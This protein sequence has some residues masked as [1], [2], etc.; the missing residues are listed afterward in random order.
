MKK[1]ILIGL[2]LLTSLLIQ[3]Q[4]DNTQPEYP[5]GI[6][7]GDTLQVVSED[8]TLW[9]ITDHQIRKTIKVNK[10]YQLAKEEV[11]LLQQKI[12]K[13]EKLNAQ[14]DTLAIKL[15]EDRDYY[16]TNWEK[17]SKNIDVIGEQ[18]KKQQK[19]TKIA[20]FGGIAGTVIGFIVGL[21]I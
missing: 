8:S 7:P 19:K 11:N 12:D 18:A 9:I 17:C 4:E 6:F 1:H 5:K 13:Y 15:T 14:R 20:V 2:F 16:K 3:A 10:K 21:L